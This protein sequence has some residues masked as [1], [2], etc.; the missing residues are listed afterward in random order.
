MKSLH[1]IE[2]EPTNASASL[3]RLFELAEVLGTLMEHGI[4]AHGLTLARARLLWV[5]LHDG[6]MTQR[7]LADALDVTPRNVT[8]LLDA[9]QVD[10][11]IHRA[12]HPTDRRATLVHLTDHGRTAVTRLRAGRDDMAAALF[13]GIPTAHLN[14]FTATVATVT[15]RLRTARVPGCDEQ[16]R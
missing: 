11:Y 8:G 12:P 10:G 15:A 3:N 4:E 16:T 1:D 6:P 13:A 5:L 14:G 9:L 7:A 2:A